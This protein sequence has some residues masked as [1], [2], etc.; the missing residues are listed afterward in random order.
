MR[1]FALKTCSTCRKAIKELRE[2]GHDPQIID[3]R[4]DIVSEADLDMITRE[5]GDHAVNTRSTTWRNLSEI[6]QLEP[7]REL[8]EEYPT[9][10]KR[11][12]IEKDGQLYLG[13]TDQ[14]RTAVL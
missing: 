1:V 8:I 9:V 5:F 14:V 2:A 7:P 3:V 10:M 4:A 11:P 6:K 12:I 13:W